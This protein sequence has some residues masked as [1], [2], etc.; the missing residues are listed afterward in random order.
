MDRWQAPTRQTHPAV[1]GF[2]FEQYELLA[3]K[4]RTMK[5]KTILTINAHPDIKKVF[6][7]FKTETVKIKYT[8]GGNGRGNEAQ[9]MI[10]MNW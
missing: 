5:G 6:D 1:I 8:V 2:G 10:V 3:D 9:E 4:M 7:E